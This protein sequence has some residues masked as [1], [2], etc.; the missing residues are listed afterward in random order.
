MK[1]A[2]L[3]MAAI[4]AASAFADKV[5]LKSGTVLTGTGAV[6]ADD[7][8]KFTSD[9]LGDIEIAADKVSYVETAQAPKVEV[10]ELPVEEKKPE[11][12]HGA[13]NVA[14][15]S[16]RGNTYKNNASVIANLNRRW[17]EDRVNID[18]GYY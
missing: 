6:V 8:V 2:I 9:D 13:I 14:F 15:E 18:F 5:Y 7:K 10:A 1:R 16:A 12:W 11:T 3:A 17:D 4:A